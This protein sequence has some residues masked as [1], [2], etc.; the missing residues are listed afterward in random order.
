M[1]GV[2]LDELIARENNGIIDVEGAIPHALELCLSEI[3]R[4]GLTEVGL[5]K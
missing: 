5:C 1:F 3:E 2:V 4:R